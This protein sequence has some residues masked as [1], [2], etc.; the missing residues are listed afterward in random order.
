ML[1]DQFQTTPVFTT[2][3]VILCAPVQKNE[4]PVKDPRTHLLCYQ[5]EGARPPNKTARLSNQF[6][7]V[8]LRVFNSRLLC[9]PS[10]KVLTAASQTL[11]P[12]QPCLVAPPNPPGVRYGTTNLALGADLSPGVRQDVLLIVET[13]SGAPPVFQFDVGGPT[14]DAFEICVSRPGPSLVPEG[15]LVTWTVEDP[16]DPAKMTPWATLLN[17]FVSPLQ[18]QAFSLVQG[19]GVL[20]VVVTAAAIN[21]FITT[22]IPPGYPSGRVLIVIPVGGATFQLAIDVGHQP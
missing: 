21:N 5:I 12:Q 10:L 13:S 20:R 11:T 8:F 17:S 15:S 22:Q 19:H 14:S 4:E 6:G 18:T 3:P 16:N 2:K 9:V 7:T 1:R